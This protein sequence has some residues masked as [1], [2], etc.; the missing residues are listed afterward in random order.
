M[1]WLT[2]RTQHYL[3]HLIREFK[4]SS[5]KWW[6]GGS[7]LILI[8]IGFL[9]SVVTLV[10][11]SGIPV[12]QNPE[13]GDAILSV[14]QVSSIQPSVVADAVRL[15][16]EL[17]GPSQE[18]R[19][20]VNQ[21]LAAYTLCAG[22]DIII[23]FNSGG[24]GSTSISQS[25][26]WESII[27]GIKKKL[28]QNGYRVATLN[29]R[30]TQYNFP[31]ILNELK[32][33]VTGYLTK[34]RDLA[35]RIEFLTRHYPKLRVILAGESIG[36]VICDSAMNYLKDN[37]RV[38]SIQTG[39]P[40]WQRN[41]ISNR[42]LVL[43]NNGFTPDA[44]SHGN[45]MTI[46]ITSLKNFLGLEDDCDGGKVLGFLSSPGHEYWW[47][48]PGVSFPIEDFLSRHFG[49]ERKYAY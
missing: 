39:T 25:A 31:G 27:N 19:E 32:E 38:F 9:T 20:M 36:T 46:L 45:V 43:N 8:I 47:Q 6:L 35:Y 17:Y 28:I 1:T 29:Y 15:S 41:T 16:Q 12:F 26:D 10:F 40:F 37:D 11:F 24:W 13:S 42:T 33:M 30:R 7:I 3:N 18:A 34:A 49:V 14:Q 5:R 48:D 23:V 2:T 44:F 21:L 22:K 4:R